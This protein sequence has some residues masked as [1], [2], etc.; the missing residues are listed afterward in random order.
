MVRGDD[1]LRPVV[2]HDAVDEREARERLKSLWAAYDAGPRDK[3][4]LAVTT[5]QARAAAQAAPAQVRG[6]LARGVEA[7]AR[8]R[9]APLIH[10]PFDSL[11][12]GVHWGGHF[13]RKARGFS[14]ANP[15]NEMLS[16][17]GY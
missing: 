14:C 9:M 6:E 12:D 2:N 5:G 15:T 1:L 10:G 16:L 17:T 7:A 3:A 8:Y 11:G 13:R 4:R